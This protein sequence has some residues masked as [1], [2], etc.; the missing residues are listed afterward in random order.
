MTR[1][2]SWSDFAAASPRL[3]ADIEALFHHYGR[4]FGYLATVRRD[5]GPRV[6][7][8]SPVIAEGGLFC[9][10]MDS[11]KRR[12]LERDERYALHAYPAEHSDDEA[13]VTGRVRPVV[14][15]ERRERLARDHRAAPHV[16]WRLFELDIE[17]AMLTHRSGEERTP[18][19]RVWRA[20]A[21]RAQQRRPP[22]QSEGPAVSNGTVARCA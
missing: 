10:V 5:G 21:R 1:M 12:D 3:A 15:P 7:P 2:T 8:V 13:Y 17:V 14:E 20:P 4:G 16:D 18:E 11:P 6:H 9:F 22:R 19:H